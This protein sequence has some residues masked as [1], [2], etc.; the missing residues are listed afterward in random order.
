MYWPFK[1]I[2]RDL[3]KT[4]DLQAIY[5]LQLPVFKAR[6]FSTFASGWEKKSKNL[7]KDSSENKESNKKKRHSIPS[8]DEGEPTET[9]QSVYKTG[10]P[11]SHR[12]NWLD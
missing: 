6:E 11:P 5:E 1:V 3:S 12:M 4:L 9:M 7:P 10:L 2:L 8:P